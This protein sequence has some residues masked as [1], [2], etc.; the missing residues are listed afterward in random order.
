VADLMVQLNKRR[1]DIVPAMVDERA[2]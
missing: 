2:A 1:L